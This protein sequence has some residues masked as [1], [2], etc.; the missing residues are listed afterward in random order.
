MKKKFYYLLI[1]IFGSIIWLRQSPKTM[2]AEKISFRYNLLEFSL[3]SKSLETYAKT[4][5]IDSNLN[6][7]LKYID[8]EDAHKLQKILNRSIAIDRVKLYR[9]LNTAVGKQILNTVGELIQ[10]SSTQNGFYALRSALILAA[11]EPD[12]LTLMNFIR[13]FPSEVMYI[14]GENSLD[15]ITTF[16]KLINYSNNAVAVIKKQSSIEAK[17]EANI[18]F[19]RYPDI[20]KPGSFT[21]KKEFLVFNDPKRDRV[22]FAELYRPQTNNYV[23]VIVISPGLGADGNNFG[24]LAEHLAS[25]GF[26]VITVNHSGSDRAQVEKFL[27]GINREIMEAQEFINRPIDISFLL[28]ELAQIESNK[29]IS[30]R[31]L[32]LEQVG[33]IGHS[34]GGY[35]AMALAGAELDFSYLEQNCKTESKQ[36]QLYN[37][38]LLLQCIALELSNNNRYQLSDSRVKAVFA[39]N[40]TI[41]SVFG[42]KGLSKIKIPITL[43][44]GT[45]DFVTPALIEQIIPFTWLEKTE[46]HLL[47]IEKGGHSYTSEGTYKENNTTPIN[48]AKAQIYKEYFQAITLAFMQNYLAAN[49]DYQIFLNSSYGYFLSHDLFKLH[50]INFLNYNEL[51]HFSI[52]NN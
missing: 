43:V 11:S 50:L 15:V 26:A 45:K 18:N 6:L 21:W 35:A 39:I 40:P 14:N 52:T 32:N 28:D 38:S 51:K 22:F 20:R 23:P 46:K 42:Q 8:R 17:K 31:S 25:Y 10:P 3:P 37:F 19:D 34:F 9:F 27:K 12:G 29:S 2:A 1:F 5:E 36:T 30:D 16:S 41:S 33:V 49:D 44:S 47:L 7:Y 48:D 4:G 24:Y 13:H